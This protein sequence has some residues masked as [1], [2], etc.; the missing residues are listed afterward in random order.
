MGVRSTLLVFES[1]LTSGGSEMGGIA[2]Q[3]KK[4]A[5]EHIGIELHTEFRGVDH[6]V[7]TVSHLAFHL[8]GNRVAEG[9]NVSLFH[10][11][12]F[13]ETVLKT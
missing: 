6:K 10:L 3:M 2:K 9:G 11:T 4:N 5:L 8:L 7:D 12:R 13:G 1:Y